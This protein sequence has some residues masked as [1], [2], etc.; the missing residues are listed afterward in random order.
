MKQIKVLAF[1]LLAVTALAVTFAFTT[2][3]HAAKAS[4]FTTQYF[5][6]VG[7]TSSITDLEDPTQWVAE[8]SDGSNH[9]NNFV[10]DLIVSA[11]NSTYIYSSGP[12]AGLPKVDVSG[13]A[14]QNDVLL[15]GGHSSPANVQPVT[16]TDYQITTNSTRRS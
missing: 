8:S 12:N 7:L 13:S 3:A 11:N 10:G 2:R 14:L 16:R 6:F 1:S 15:A 4:K 9:V 5:K